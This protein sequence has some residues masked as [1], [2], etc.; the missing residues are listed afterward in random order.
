MNPSMT[1]SGKER[2][3]IPWNRKWNVVRRHLPIILKPTAAG[4]I[5]VIIWKLV[6]YD[7]GIFFSKHSEN[8]ILFLIMPLVAFIYVIFA[9]VAVESVFSEYKIISKCVVTRDL[10]TF[11]LYRDEQL[12]IMMHI[13]VGSPSFILIILSLFFNYD[14]A[15]IGAV[16]IFLIT[17]V[18]VLTW[19]ISTELDDYERSIWF[20]EKIPKEWYEIDIESFFKEKSKF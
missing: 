18:V 1:P 7:N 2:N 9:S 20:K 17:F 16:A 11:L 15:I 14:D 4:L 13:L 6:L 12:P 5:L 10:E 19:V 3:Y 8:P